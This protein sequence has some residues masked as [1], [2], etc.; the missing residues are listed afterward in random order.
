MMTRKDYVKIAKA[1]S[2]STSN[3]NDDEF[4]SKPYLVDELCTI[5]KEDN[6]NFNPSIFKNACNKE[7]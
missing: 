1:I 3:S 2:E 6:P 7:G 5:F 4:V